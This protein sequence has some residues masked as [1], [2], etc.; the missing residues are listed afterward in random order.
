MSRGCPKRVPHVHRVGDLADEFVL[1]GLGLI[2]LGLFSLGLTD[3]AL[4][5]LFWC[6]HWLLLAVFGR[7]LASQPQ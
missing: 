5:L 4:G 1:F 2:G 7:H 6:R 3:L